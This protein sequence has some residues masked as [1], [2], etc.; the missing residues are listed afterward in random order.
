MSDGQ[1]IV[2]YGTMKL[3][4]CTTREFS[5]TP[6][7]DVSR[8]D[9]KSWKFTV[10]V[11]GI[12]HGHSEWCQWITPQFA[13]DSSSTTY[14]GDAALA[15]RNVRY[16]LPPR[17]YFD[18]TV[19]A[20]VTGAG[21]TTLL[22]AFPI[23][24]LVAGGT[25]PINLPNGL[26]A[27]DVQ[28]GPICTEFVVTHVIGNN[29][30]Q[31]EAAF[32]IH[33]LECDPD[34]G[35]TSNNTGV[36]SHR[37]SCGDDIDTDM[38]TVRTYSGLLEIATASFS[39]H[40]FRYLCVPPLSD[41]FRRDRMNFL[42]TEDGLKLQYSITDTEIAA[43]APKPATRW[44]I[45]HSEGSGMGMMAH[46]ELDISL[47]GDGNAN[48][49]DLIK[50]AIY[51]LTNKLMGHKPDAPKK[52]TYILDDFTITDHIGDVQAITAHAKLRKTNDVLEGLQFGVER[53]GKPILAADLPLALADYNPRQSRGGRTGETPEYQGPASLVGIFRCYLQNPCYADHGINN[54]IENNRLGSD[55]NIPPAA[56]P[57]ATITAL[58]VPDL[59]PTT[60]TY[61][62]DSHQDAAYTFYQCESQYKSHQMR[63]A[64][65]R[66]SAPA[67]PPVVPDTT[68]ATC[69]VSLCRPQSRLI[70]RVTA[71]RIGKQPEFPDPESLFMEEATKYSGGGP[72]AIGMKLLSSTLAPATAHYT[73]TGAKVYRA[74]LQAKYALKRKPGPDEILKI[75]SNPWTKDNIEVTDATLTKT[76]WA[77]S[78]ITT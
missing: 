71:E 68:D 5:Q 78:G 42:A 76:P 64:M 67:D 61:Y 65:P 77:D 35:A 15:H 37:W 12:V 28:N 57:R 3:W 66:A 24:G 54:S 13:G 60:P 1:T 55:R 34:S 56:L 31:V 9:L 18:M 59:A 36:L 20:D 63:V 74:R 7:F 19:G 43:S 14:G 62:S 58:V 21:G 70:V 46:S 4:R 32:E 38:R 48:K 47:Q 27:C 69:I 6:D 53:L 52:N 72:P 30:F 49:G 39:P 26:T 44:S 10:K 33:K 50:I 22:S 45:R 40:W 41:G 11:S 73:A 25:A 75:G 8:T 29:L 51:V 17:Q 2:T 16:R 23:G